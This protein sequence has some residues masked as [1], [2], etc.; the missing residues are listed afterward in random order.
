MLGKR[1]VLALIPARGGSKGLPRKNMRIVDGK[2][3]L[4]YTIDAA[5]ASRY[6]DKIYCT[7]DDS[8]ILEYSL[9]CKI[10][11]LRR[12]AEA[13]DDSAT[14][15]HV[16]DHFVSILDKKTLSRDPVIIYLQPTSPL[17]SNQHIDEAL[18]LMVDHQASV[19]VSVMPMKLSPF[20]AMR[21]NDKGL[22]TP[23]F[24]EEVGSSNR[25]ELPS[26]FYPNGAIYAFYVKEF[27][28]RGKFPLDMSLPFIMSEKD[29]IDIDSEID[30]EKFKIILGR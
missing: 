13:S 7:S 4:A 26:I 14:A 20:K 28:V 8:E 17:R 21:L 15:T 3:L 12:P 11:A 1:E 5:M 29:S 9:S 30:L 16:V 6:I 2:P 23:F 10:Q 18:S 25:Q 24:S 22:L 27:F 19:L